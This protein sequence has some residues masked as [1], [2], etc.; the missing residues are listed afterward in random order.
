MLY[1]SLLFSVVSFH[2]GFGVGFGSGFGVDFPFGFGVG[3][4]N[5]VWVGLFDFGFGV[6]FDFGVGE[7]WRWVRGI[8]LG[9]KDGLGQGGACFAN[10]LMGRCSRLPW[11]HSHLC[12]F[13]L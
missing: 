10:S 1:C 13:L 2:L 5:G 12:S 7:G 3:F 11:R 9:A 8:A 6:G 4:K